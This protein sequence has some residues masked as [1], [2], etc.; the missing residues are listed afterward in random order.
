MAEYKAAIMMAD[1][2]EECEALNV[3]DLLRRADIDVKMVSINGE[4]HVT[5]SHSIGID[6]DMDIADLFHSEQGGEM[7]PSA[8]ADGLDMVIL[9]YRLVWKI[10][11]MSV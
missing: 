1:G 9:P 3:V 7:E 4:K 5:G 8:V 11:S 10:P 2:L 6:T